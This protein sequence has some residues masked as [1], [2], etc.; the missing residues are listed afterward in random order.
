MKQ[1]NGSV[2]RC[3]RKGPTDVGTGRARDEQVALSSFIEKLNERFG[4]NFIKAG[5]PARLPLGGR[6]GQGGREDR[7]GCDGEHI[8]ELL[9]L[10]RK[11][12]GRAVHRTDGGQRGD[13][14]PRHERQGG[15]QRRGTLHGSSMSGSRT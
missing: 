8:Q 10:P 4:I 5:R 2:G 14:R 12:V 1:S 7:R 3:L 9:I 11:D 15:P 13:L 6:V